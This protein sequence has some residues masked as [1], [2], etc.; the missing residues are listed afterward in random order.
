M[1]LNNY[2]IKN[3]YTV[4]IQ[5]AAS[6]TAQTWMFPD[7]PFLRTK[8]ITAII[9]SATAVG[10]NTGLTNY[11][12][13][14]FTNTATSAFLT[15]QDDKGKQFIQNMPLRELL[16]TQEVKV[17]AAFVADNYVY[18]ANTDGIKYIDPRIVVWTKSFV[19]LPVA[20]GTANLCLQFTVLYNN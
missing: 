7:I 8:P 5:P 3:S 9:L 18:G 15:L 20:T 13:T 11:G 1:I 16:I 14:M 2:G 6:D 12:Y 17:N 10:V 4:E 19:Y